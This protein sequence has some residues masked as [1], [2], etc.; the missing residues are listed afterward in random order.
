MKLPHAVRA[1]F[2]RHGRA[3]GRARAARMTP[4]ERRR[5]ARTAASARWIRRR[6]GAASFASLGLPGGDLVDAGL[7]DLAAGVVSEASLLVSIARPRLQRERIPVGEPLA[8]PER[9]LYEALVERDGE[10]A[11]PRY[12]AL[13]QRMTSFADACRR[14]RTED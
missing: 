11:H 12:T 2:R 7:A 5:V 6:F 4:E 9:R 10:L 3:G 13:L 14:V 8:E 1:A